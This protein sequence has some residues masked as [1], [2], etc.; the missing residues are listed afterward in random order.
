[1]TNL[2]IEFAGMRF[3]NPFMLASA[4][5][6]HT[7]GMIERAFAAGWG[8]YQ[9]ITGFKGEVET[10]NGAQCDGCG[11]CVMVCPLGSITMAPR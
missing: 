6:A 8:G 2:S 4:P 10:I 9:A 3:P 7:A 11:L 1:M 5:P